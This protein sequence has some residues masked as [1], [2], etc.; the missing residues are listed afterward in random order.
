MSTDPDIVKRL[1]SIEARIADLE[2]SLRDRGKELKLHDASGNDRGSVAIVGD[3]AGVFL[4]GKDGRTHASIQVTADGLPA[5][6]LG[7]RGNKG[8]ISVVVQKNGK[9][10]VS[11]FDDDNFQ[12]GAVTIENRS[13]KFWCSPVD[14]DGPLSS[15]TI[16][17]DEGGRP[18]L[19]L[20]DGNGVL[21]FKAP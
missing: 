14:R 21:L 3:T 9:P 12:L 19:R 1:E 18:S 8:R 17:C 2:T 4:A 13:L 7:R 20:E 15:L 10:S 16:G 11:F 6:I 5:L